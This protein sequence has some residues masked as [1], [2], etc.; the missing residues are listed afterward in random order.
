M[1]KWNFKSLPNYFEKAIYEYKGY[2]FPTIFNGFMY[3]IYNDFYKNL[4]SYYF[5]WYECFKYIDTSETP[6]HVDDLLDPL[7]NIDVYPIELCIRLLDVWYSEYIEYLSNESTYYKNLWSNA[8]R[9][10]IN[11]IKRKTYYH[12]THPF[13]IMTNHTS[14]YMYKK[15][16]FNICFNLRLVLY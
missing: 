7:H 15:S 13:S 10:V 5:I 8:L 1:H 12:K 3:S 6:Y 16:V 9:T 2:V 14:S 4:D 11:I